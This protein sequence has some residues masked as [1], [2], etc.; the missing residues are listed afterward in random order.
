[1]VDFIIGFLSILAFLGLVYL[2]FKVVVLFFRTS[3]MI[4][5]MDTTPKKVIDEKLPYAPVGDLIHKE[6]V[7]LRQELASAHR[8]IESLTKGRVLY[9]KLVIAEL[10]IKK[11]QDAFE[12]W[13]K[14]DGPNENADMMLCDAFKIKYDTLMLRRYVADEM[15]VLADTAP[16]N[17]NHL[18][19]ARIIM[20][21]EEF[22]REGSKP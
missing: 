14:T 17:G 13:R 2:G 12:E 18:A 20:A 8:E 1:M 22:E 4:L 9:E 5:K 10:Q 19:Q 11:Q 21:A 16:I 6:N 7:E 3:W 15:R